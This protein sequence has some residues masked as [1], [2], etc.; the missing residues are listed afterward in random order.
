M[1]AAAERQRQ[2]WRPLQCLEHGSPQ[3]QCKDDEDEIPQQLRDR[4]LVGSCS[5]PDDGP[6]SQAPAANHD[7]VCAV[8]KIGR[9]VFCASGGTS[10]RL[11][12]LRW[13]KL[14]QLRQELGEES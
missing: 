6:H 10:A 2:Q 4:R 5:Q 8:S 12:V 7:A 13:G 14:Q 11:L 3:G 1:E 9:R